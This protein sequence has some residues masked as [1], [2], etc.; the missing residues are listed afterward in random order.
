[1]EFS[2][3]ARPEPRHEEPAD[4][5]V[6]TQRSR[7]VHRGR[8]RMRAFYFAAAAFWGFVAGSAA[9]VACLQIAGRPLPLTMSI[10]GT[11]SGAAVVAVVGGIVLALAY[12]EAAHRRLR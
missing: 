6:G 5:S 9:V 7:A 12:R 11:L 4:P 2:S 10:V 3:E 1:M 8:S